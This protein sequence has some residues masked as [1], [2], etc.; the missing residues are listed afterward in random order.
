[1]PGSRKSETTV[2]LPIL[3]DFINMMNSKDS[4]YSFVFHATDENKENIVD[5]IKNKNLKILMSFQMKA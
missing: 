5:Y 4:N 1:M 3:I 2:L